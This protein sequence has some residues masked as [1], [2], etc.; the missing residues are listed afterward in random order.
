MLRIGTAPLNKIAI[1]GILFLTLA[2]SEAEHLRY[3]AEHGDVVA[4][5]ELGKKYCLL[6]DKNFPNDG[7]AAIQWLLK[8]SEKGDVEA[9]CKLAECYELYQ[10]REMQEKAFYWYSKAAEKNDINA[11]V[12]L[13]QGYDQE[14]LNR[15]RD[16]KMWKY[17]MDRADATAARKQ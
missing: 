13:A 9:M 14:K 15:K 8:A 5:R 7:N 2:C 17:W 11:M 10:E 3:K 6:Y 12:A 1:I 16:L 4:M